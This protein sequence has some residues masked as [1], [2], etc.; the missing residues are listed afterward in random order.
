M[1]LATWN[2]SASQKPGVNFG[3]C[4]AV[5][6]GG[7]GGSTGEQDEAQDYAPEKVNLQLLEN[8]MVL[9][10]MV[11]KEGFANMEEGEVEELLDTNPEALTKDEFTELITPEQEMMPDEEEEKEEMI[12]ENKF[13]LDNTTKDLHKYKSGLG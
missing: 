5:A 9:A 13:T 8:I 6:T 2:S 12:T 11:G 3:S 7:W 4:E 10:M 1:G